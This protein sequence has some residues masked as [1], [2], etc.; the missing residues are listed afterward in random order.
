MLHKLIENTHLLEDTHIPQGVLPDIVELA[1]NVFFCPMKTGNA[2]FIV[3]S[4]GIITVDT[5]YPHDQ[6]S[7]L[8]RIR[9][10]FFAHPLRY[11]LCTDTQ[12]GANVRP[13]LEEAWQ[14]GTM[15][16]TIIAQRN[17]RIEMPSCSVQYD[18]LLSLRIGEFLINIHHY[19]NGG[20]NDGAW[21][22]IVNYNIIFSGILLQTGSPKDRAKVLSAEAD[23]LLPRFGSP[24]SCQR[25]LESN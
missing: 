16:P 8:R 9:R 10:Y 15:A 14:S 17:Q 18:D 2:G 5:G 24:L 4:E 21:V 3:T 7:L 6:R 23:L 13:L 11:I 19:D 12:G 22:H 20:C 1:P 25:S